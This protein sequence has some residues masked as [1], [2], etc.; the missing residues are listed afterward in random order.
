MGDTE[1][2]APVPS[3]LVR[4][5]VARV[6]RSETFSKAPSLRRLLSYVVDQSVDGRADSVKEYS[7]GVEVFGRGESFDPRADTIVRVQARRLRSK[8][9]EYYAVAG[10]ADGIE[11]EVPKGGYL[12]RF[13]PVPESARHRL[14][15][16]GPG[17]RWGADDG[18]SGAASGP[19]RL[20]AMPVPRTSLIGRELEVATLRGFLRSADIRLLTMTGP[21]GSGKTR[22]ALEVASHVAEDFPGGVCFVGLGSV[23]DIADV[24][25]KLAQAL[26]L[27]RIDSGLIEEALREHVR[28]SVRERTLIV[29]DNFEQLLPAAPLLAA[30]VESTPALTLLV[31][32]RLVLHVSG[33]QC[34]D[35][36]P[37]R[38]PDLST[39]P[40]VHVLAE[41]PAVALFVRQARSGQASFELTAENAPAIAE[42]C[43]RLD[44]LPLAIELAAARI[45]VLSPSQIRARLES[46]LD[47]LV[48]GSRDLPVRQQT[49]RQAID[50]SHELL[51]PSETR[52][53]RRL[54][55][56]AGP[57]TLEGAEAVCS[58][59]Q[60]LDTGVLEGMSSLVDKSL[61][62]QVDEDHGELRFAMLETVREYA[63][64][65][66]DA[67]GERAATHR[68]HAAY[69]IVLAEEGSGPI[70][71]AARADWLARCQR[72]HDNHRAALEYLIGA[73]DSAWAL[74]LA[75]ALFEYLG[76]GRAP[77]GGVRALRGDPAAA[78][79]G[80]A[81]PGAGH[82]HRV[83]RPPRARLR[84]VAP[85]RGSPRHLPRSGRSEGRG[86]PV[87]QPG[88]QPALSR[89]L[90]RCTL[91][92][93][94]EREHLS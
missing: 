2:T 63:L 31:T 62:H 87:E 66:L 65:Q 4:A 58:P 33:E 28:T 25:S 89:R 47:L 64:E 67:S 80:G 40:P 75:L 16:P 45:R 11:I 50:W 77:V 9:G 19:L 71:A 46:R 70:T 24:G 94:A 3:E 21:G 44:G 69:C 72:E 61:I 29:L 51:T 53:F 90:R 27:R 57:C 43:A 6:L 73:D 84:V 35:V 15:A 85:G 52:L 60:D 78:E 14:P 26:G 83:R 13:R 30:L 81:N 38:V 88:R 34:F 55:V 86:R 37:L 7:I 22:L 91:L 48:A 74:R 79:H 42:I 5:H 41:S 1:Q 54:A 39:S 92:A 18:D 56:F 59:Q 8:L 49:L 17:Y 23:T 93:R 12:P 20:H 82:G 10:F 32:S 76:S 36:P 68:A